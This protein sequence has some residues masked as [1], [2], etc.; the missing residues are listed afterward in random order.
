MIQPQDAKKRAN[1]EMQRS[2]DL[3]VLTA[4]IILPAVVA[5]DDLPAVDQPLPHSNTYVYE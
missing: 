4:G 1:Q 2:A 5:V 3:P